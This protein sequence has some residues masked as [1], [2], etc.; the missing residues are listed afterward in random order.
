MSTLTP[1]EFTNFLIEAAD[2]KEK[3]ISQLKIC[4]QL[5]EKYKTNHSALRKRWMRHDNNK[6][7]SKKI[8]KTSKCNVL[9]VEDEAAI[10]TLLRTACKSNRALQKQ[11]LISFVRKRYRNNDS[12]WRGDKWIKGFLGR[13]KD[14]LKVSNLKIATPGRVAPSTADACEEFI[15]IMKEITPEL[16]APNTIN[17]DEFQL[18]MTGWGAGRQRIEAVRTD[19][20]TLSSKVQTGKRGSCVGSMISFVTADGNLLFNTLCLKPDALG[21]DEE[22]GYIDVDV[23]ELNDHNTRR[24]PVPQMKIYSES[25]MINNDIWL[26]IWQRFLDHISAVTP[27]KKYFCFM[28]NLPQHRQ[29]ECIEEGLKV[30]VEI[31]FL[32]KNTTHFIQPLDQFIFGTM[33]KEMNKETSSKMVWSDITSLN[34]I[35]RDSVPG[36]IAKAFTSDKIKAS[37]MVCGIYPFNENK[38]RERYNENLGRICSNEETTPITV[39]EEKCREMIEFIFKKEAVKQ[40][41]G[42]KR[43]RAPIKLSQA[44]TSGHVLQIAEEEARKKEEESA[45][46]KRRLEDRNRAKEQREAELKARK[47]AAA[48]KK[49]EK[50]TLKKYATCH[51]CQRKRTE[52]TRDKLRWAKCEKCKAFS[53]C[54]EHREDM[55]MH[56]DAC[57][58]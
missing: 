24:N 9:P 58:I 55:W 7:R 16:N 30:K 47:D 31:I 50:E 41:T 49:K 12:Y 10:I 46:K 21:R 34:H 45:A 56:D 32:P 29:L 17:V 8:Q 18:K 39:V 11:E 26:K 42:G 27:G 3:G 1:Y 14:I 37:F 22:T 54:P 13:N 51:T 43:P 40:L 38:I 15:E 2:L 48:I 6:K 23:S 5:A 35:I 52:K 33:K 19:G 53:L 36:C 4:K 44:Y 25:G 57:Q 28:D 20:N